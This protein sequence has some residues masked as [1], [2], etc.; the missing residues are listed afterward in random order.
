MAEHQVKTLYS[1][2]E[3]MPL[4]MLGFRAYLVWGYISCHNFS[5]VVFYTPGPEQLTEGFIWA[6]ISREIRVLHQG[7]EAGMLTE[8]ESR[9]ITS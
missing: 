2:Q 3:F 7:E 4:V 5:I 9:E 1:S 8:A 6:D